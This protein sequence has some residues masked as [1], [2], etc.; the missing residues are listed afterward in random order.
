MR[1]LDLPKLRSNRGTANNVC[2]P[3]IVYLNIIGKCP[4]NVFIL[5]TA[6]GDI[7]N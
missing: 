5:K 6:R 3:M 1:Q 7:R 2:R 4:L